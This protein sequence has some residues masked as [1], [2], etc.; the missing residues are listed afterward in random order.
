MSD[1]NVHAARQRIALGVE[2]DGS[3]FSGWQKQQSPELPT[4]QGALEKALSKVA[5]CPITTLCAGRTDA[6]VHATSQVVHFDTPID[7]GTKAWTQ[8]VNSLLPRT[9]RV[10]WAQPVASDFHARFSALARRYHY[11]IL[12]RDT[13]SAL[14]AGKVTPM[15][16]QLDVAAMH[17]AAQF[18]LGEQDFSS[19][20]AAGCQSNTANR[21][22]HHARVAQC[23]PFVILDIQANAFLQ[24]MVRNIA[25]SL[26]DI[27]HGKQPVE[28]LQELLQARDRTLASMTAPADGL[29]LTSV[30]YPAEAELP[31]SLNLP[32]VL[33][34]TGLDSS[35]SR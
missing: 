23:G 6:G 31:P 3:A 4:V 18:L 16:Q 7:R 29:Y 24:H 34:V 1:D 11:V 22:V 10:L 32:P 26:L 8:G 30:K 27:G 5:N 35:Q 12:Q 20:R 25:G 19:F 15:R 14:L 2:Y 33:L 21:N 9:V 28:W 13:E 17:E